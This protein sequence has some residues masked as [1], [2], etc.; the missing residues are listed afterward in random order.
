MVV[1]DE[2]FIGIIEFW[3]E[4]R[5]NII[6]LLNFGTYNVIVLIEH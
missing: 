6:K 5:Q 3:I 2:H 4:I 1:T